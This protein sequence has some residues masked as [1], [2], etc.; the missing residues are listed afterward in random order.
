[1]GKEAKTVTLLIAADAAAADLSL[2]AEAVERFPKLG[3]RVLEVLGSGGVHFEVVPA[4]GADQSLLHLQLAEPLAQLVAAVRAGKFDGLS[5][6]D[7]FHG[8]PCAS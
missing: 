1:M 4:P 5:V 6:E 2:L 7:A 8:G 3:E